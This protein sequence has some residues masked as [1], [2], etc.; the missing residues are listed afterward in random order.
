VALDAARS[1]GVVAMVFG[2]TL[3]AL[4]SVEA[5]ACPLMVE[6]WKA[7]GFTAP[8]FLL[9]AG[10]TVT[11]AVGRSRARGLG[12]AQE[13][14]PRVLLLLAVGYG[15]RFPGWNLPALL[16]GDPVVWQHFLAFDALHAIAVGLLAVAIV[17][18]LPWRRRAA[19][20]VLLVLLGAL[21]VVLTPATPGEPPQNLATLALWEATGGTSPFPL[22][23]WLA[24]FF[25]G[26]AVGLLAPGDPMKRAAVLG[27]VGVTLVAATCWQG[28][29]TMPPAEPALVLYRVGAILALLAALGAC[30]VRIAAA[31]APLG[32]ASLGIYALHVAIVYGWCRVEGLASR[33]GPSLGLGE[34]ASVAL[35]VLV[36]SALIHRALRVASAVAAAGIRRARMRAT[37]TCSAALAHCRPPSP[38]RRKS[39]PSPQH[40]L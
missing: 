30:P 11:L 26:G 15:L 38:R 23:P 5:R 9:V 20:G 27:G 2:H 40:L 37:L 29:G 6:Y 1:L 34:A 3:D 16:A 8:L 13:R 33:I 36:C 32:R 17:L 7:R 25:A 12:I 31:L 19:A 24:Y 18:G 14:L 28:V 39:R 10:W 21:A 22:L 35:L 4:L